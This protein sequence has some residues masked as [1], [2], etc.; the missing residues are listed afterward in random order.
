MYHFQDDAYSQHP[1]IPYPFTQASNAQ[2]SIIS[3]QNSIPIH[4]L[5][6][7]NSL[8]I[9][10]KS[11]TTSV[12]IIAHTLDPALDCIR[13]VLI[14]IQYDENHEEK[15]VDYCGG[16]AAINSVKMWQVV[17]LLMIE[18]TIKSY[19]IFISTYYYKGIDWIHRY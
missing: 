10:T 13:L 1:D 17:L 12:M 5:S 8:G 14:E 18:H 15:S 6:L 16:S 7:F 19:P 2:L 4:Q 11:Y 9:P 3:T